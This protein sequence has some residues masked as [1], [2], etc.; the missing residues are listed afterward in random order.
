ME[1]DSSPNIQND[2]FNQVR[3]DKARVVIYLN[4]GKKLM[5]R[6]RS[7][8]KFTVILDN[9]QGEQMIFKHAIA[10]V[11]STKTFGNYINFDPASGREKEA[12]EAEGSVEE[13]RGEGKDTTP[14]E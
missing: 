9:G 11:S 3:K 6:I 1:K 4:S 2:F 7:F 8:D 13:D 5:G 10:T 12:P 14:A